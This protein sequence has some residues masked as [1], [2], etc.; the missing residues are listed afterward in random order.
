[1]PMAFRIGVLLLVMGMLKCSGSDFVFVSVAGEQRVA[2]LERDAR[3]KIEPRHSVAT[4][5][6]PGAMCLDQSR[7]RLF[8]SLK[9]I[10][11]LASFQIANDGSLQLLNSVNAGADPSFLE[12][13]RSGR[14]LIT[15]YYQ[16]GQVTVHQIDNDGSIK[17]TPIQSVLTDEKAHG[18]LFDPLE[19]YVFVPHTRPDSIF[20]FLFD[21]QSGSLIANDTPKVQRPD[22]TGPR[23]LAFHPNGEFVVSSDEQGSSVSSY[24]FYRQSGTLEPVDRQ[25]SLPLNN[26][27]AKNSTAHVDIHPN[28]Q[29]VYVANR[30]HD[31]IACLRI[32]NTSGRLSDLQFF[33]TEKTPRSFDISPDGRW[34]IAAGQN[35]GHL[36]TFEI[37][38]SGKLI[39]R[40]T[41]NVGETP[42]W[43]QM[44]P[45]D[46]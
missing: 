7:G 32:N 43:V 26:R 20:Q 6:R 23:H 14:Y 8:V 46:P 24:R 21:K 42:W 12:I 38:P 16:A 1:M 19:K 30:G 41:F 9:S 36:A 17:R 13:A 34:L 4:E 33:P 27:P 45:I 15:A 22:A 44:M 40:S 11:K 31:S 28:G 39:R 35:S 10:G 3:G 5:G 29:F 18:V 37:Q 2:T 25:S